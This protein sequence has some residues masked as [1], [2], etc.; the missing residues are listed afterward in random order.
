MP[1]Y[2]K[3][4]RDRIPEIIQMNGEKLAYRRIEGE[5]FIREAKHK[6]KEEMKEYVEAQNAEQAIEELADLLELIYCL[7]ERHGY[8][9]K[10]LEAIR[11]DKSERRGAFHEG[12]FLETVGD[13]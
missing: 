9:R 12:W 13:D 2:H 6:L 3:L 4:V 10:E 7:A 11:A 5:E 1:S 8:S